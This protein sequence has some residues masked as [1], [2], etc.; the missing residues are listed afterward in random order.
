MKATAIDHLN[1]SI[2]E[3][4]VDEYIQF[5]HDDLGF[6]TEYVDEYRDGARSYFYIRL[7]SSCILHVSPT[8]AFDP[9]DRNNFNHFALFVDEQIETVKDRIAETSIEIQAEAVRE[10]AIGTFP[11]VYIDDPAGYRVE[12][13]VRSSE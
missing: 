9:P 13:K 7:G 12:I 2:P 1:L 8:D 5:Y 10:G 3:D 4:S 11:N 6:E